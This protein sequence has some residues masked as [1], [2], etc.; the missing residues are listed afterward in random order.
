MSASFLELLISD[1]RL[2]YFYFPSLILH[3]MDELV[4]FL[5]FVVV[6]IL[7]CAMIEHGALSRICPAI[8][9]VSIIGSS[10]LRS[11]S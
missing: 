8:N 7:F 6:G 3:D 2:E 1:F 9:D 5:Q 4:M 11:K 10:P